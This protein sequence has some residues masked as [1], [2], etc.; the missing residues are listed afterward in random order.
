[1]PLSDLSLNISLRGSQTKVVDLGGL[2]FPIQIGKTLAYANGTGA[3]QADRL[4]TDTNTLAASANVDLDLAGALTDVFLDSVVF[5]K[6]KA[7]FVSADA[8]NTNNVVIGGAAAT[9]FVGFF[10]AATHTASVRPGGF[11]STG[12]TDATG[13]T[14]GAGASDLL[15]FANSGAG[16]SVTYTVAIIG[17]SV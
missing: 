2:T 5:A 16:T 8:G 17:T 9:Q 15:R 13:W 6:V 14:V 11:F 10:G 12:C 1:M 3:G 4:Y 7:I